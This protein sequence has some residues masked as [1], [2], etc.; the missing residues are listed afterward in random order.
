MNTLLG[1]VSLAG[2]LIFNWVGMSKSEE[3]YKSSVRRQSELESRQ[4]AQTL[5]QNIGQ[6]RQRQ[7]EVAAQ[8]REQR[9]AWKF[10]EEERDYNRSRDS[11]NNFIG[12]LSANPTAKRQLKQIW[13]K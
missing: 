11:M 12:I 5:A 8:E 2:S 9:R 3:Q 4:A 10:R 7:E 1:L 13:G 6:R